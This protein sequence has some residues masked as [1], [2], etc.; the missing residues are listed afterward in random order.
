MH[1][2]EI[3]EGERGRDKRIIRGVRRKNPQLVIQGSVYVHRHIRLVCPWTRVLIVGDRKL[4]RTVLRDNHLLGSNGSGRENSTYYYGQPKMNGILRGHGNLPDGWLC[5]S[6]SVPSIIPQFA[7]RR[8]I[9]RRDS[10]RMDALLGNRSVIDHQHD[11][12]AANQ[13]VRLNTQ[14]PL[15]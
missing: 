6:G 14:F 10:H 12:V 11:I 8:S 5:K 4:Y 3:I 1:L 13:A 2:A 15:L 7:Q 9:L